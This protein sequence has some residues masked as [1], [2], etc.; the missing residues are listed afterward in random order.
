MFDAILLFDIKDEEQDKKLNKLSYKRV[1]RVHN[2]RD[3]VPSPD[4]GSFDISV[5]AREREDS[6]RVLDMILPIVQ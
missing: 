1:I 2:I 6:L 3:N 4:I 5:N